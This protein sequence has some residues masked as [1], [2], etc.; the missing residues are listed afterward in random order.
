MC[1]SLIGPQLGAC[2]G[3][4]KV[5]FWSDRIVNELTGTY[6]KATVCK[7]GSSECL[8]IEPGITK[9]LADSRDFDE[10]LWAWSGWYDAT[11]SKM[12]ESYIKLVEIMNAAAQEKGLKDASVNWMNELET[13][14]LDAVADSLYEQLKP[15]YEQLHAFVRRKLRGFYGPDKFNSKKIPMHLLGCRLF[16]GKKKFFCLKLQF[17]LQFFSGN[18]WGQSWDNIFDIVAPYPK[19]KELNITEKLLEN[20]FSPLKMFQVHNYRYSG[21]A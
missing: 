18:L 20:N 11:G 21:R 12:K 10:L 8:N 4:N 7:P 14:N 3:L 17:F 1:A 15:F 13:D 6:A 2:C 16:F 5:V 9:I 19:V